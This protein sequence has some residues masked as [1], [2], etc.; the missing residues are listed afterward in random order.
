MQY[1]GYLTDLEGQTHAVNY[2][3]SLGGCIY[4]MNLF[5][6]FTDKEKDTLYNEKIVSRGNT[7][8]IWIKNNYTS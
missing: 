2:N 4:G 8:K 7:V 6:S 1:T 5:L 3:I